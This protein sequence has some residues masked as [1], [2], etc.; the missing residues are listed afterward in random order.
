MKTNRFVLLLGVVAICTGAFFSSCK[1]LNDPTTLGG[2]L[3]P[4]VDNITTFDTTIDVQSFSDIFAIANDSTR[5]VGNDEHFLGR[6]TND[7]I[8]GTTDAQLFLEL[9]PASYPYVFRNIGGADSLH[10]DSIVLALD[11]VET[12]GDSTIPQTINVYELNS[13]FRADT[14]YYLNRNTFTTTGPALGSR[15]VYPYSLDDSIKVPYDTSKNQLRIR[16]DNTFGQRLLNYDSISPSGAYVNDSTFKT[17][18]R[19]FALKSE[20]GGN[21]VMGFTLTGANTKLA[22]YYRYQKGG[23][24]VAHEDTTVDYFTF[25]TAAASANYVQRA[26]SS[27]VTAAAAAGADPLIYLSNAP[28]T[29]ATI[30]IPGLSGLSN[31][32]VHR[33]EL[34]MEQVYDPSDTLFPPPPALQLDAYDPAK[35]TYRTIPY[36][37]APDGSGG[38]NGSSFGA[39]ATRIIDNGGHVVKVWKFNISRYVQHVLTGTLPVYDFRVFAPYYTYEQYGVPPGTDIQQL[40]YINPFAVQGRV[41]LGGGSHPTQR[42]RLHIIYSKI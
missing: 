39:Y 25:T 17:K 36:D 42:M 11:Y 24:G 15:I 1:K 16:L 38:Y 29:F 21:A 14:G 4:E 9:K 32:V 34:I 20:A 2:G 35:S 41:R 13:E 18:F 30:K 12:Y 27:Q 5:S 23:T 26:F 10:I 40:F 19:G 33:A 7:P 3:I 28:G 22:I 8:F 37:F 31:R 6:I